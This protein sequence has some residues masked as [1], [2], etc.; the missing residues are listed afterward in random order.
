MKF[1]YKKCESWWQ[2]ESENQRML[3]KLFGKVFRVQK[4]TSIVFFSERD[5]S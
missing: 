5:V 4:K 1:L 3:K 2:S